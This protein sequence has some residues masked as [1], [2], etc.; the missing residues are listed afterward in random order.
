M[1]SSFGE[2]DPESNMA[3]DKHFSITWHDGDEFTFDADVFAPTREEAIRRFAE[4][5]DDIIVAINGRPLTPSSFFKAARP[6]WKAA[7]RV[8]VND[9]GLDRIDE[10]ADTLVNEAIALG[11]GASAAA[12]SDDAWAWVQR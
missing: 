4:V 10:R 9:E 6:K 8:G 3:K 7:A 1:S 5:N 2:N 11:C 12:I